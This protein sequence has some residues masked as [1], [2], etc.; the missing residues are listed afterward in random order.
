M[1]AGL[2]TDRM[3]DRLAIEHLTPMLRWLPTERSGRR[4]TE[5]LLIL[6][7]KAAKLPE[8]ETRRNFDSRSLEPRRAG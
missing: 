2:R 5:K 8:T 7:G 6:T 3:R 4:L 1:R